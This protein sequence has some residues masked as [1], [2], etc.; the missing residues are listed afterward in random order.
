MKIII[1][2]LS[3]I[4]D[5]VMFSPA[6][7]SL[8]DK[9]PESEIEMMVMFSAVKDIYEQNPAINKIHFI[10]FLNQPA[11]KSFKQVLALRKNKYDA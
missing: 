10:D 6:L 2:A 4:G 1:N 11:L 5:A 9:L 3:G 7:K 8:K